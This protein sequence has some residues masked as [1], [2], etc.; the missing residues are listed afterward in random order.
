MY[1]LEF[2]I[3]GDKALSRVIRMTGDAIKDMSPQMAQ[4]GQVV[5]ESAISNID[6]Q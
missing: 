2:Q 5:R 1:A 4:I 3:D 6:D